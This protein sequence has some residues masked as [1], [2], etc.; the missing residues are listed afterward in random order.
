[1]HRDEFEIEPEAALFIDD[2]F[3]D[4]S[5]IDDIVLIGRGAAGMAWY[6]IG[7]EDSAAE[8]KGL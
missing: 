1:M 2:V 5:R 7:V 8:S 6:G 3:G 4:E